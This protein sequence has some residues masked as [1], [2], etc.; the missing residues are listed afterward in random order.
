MQSIK[1]RPPLRAD[2]ISLIGSLFLVFWPTL[3]G[4]IVLSVLALLFLIFSII[5]LIRTLN[6]GITV[7][8][9]GVLC[10]IKKQQFQLAYHEISAVT[11]ADANN[12]KTLLIVSGYQSYSIRIE[13]AEAV[14]ATIAHNMATLKT[15]P[16]LNSS[17]ALPC[18]SWVK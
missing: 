11:L 8:D 16:N 4:N 9:A 2:I 18:P 12:Q 14:R 6:D 3:T 10:K 17:T 1:G 13:N 15:A 7:D 5:R